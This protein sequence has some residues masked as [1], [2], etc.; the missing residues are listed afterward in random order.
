MRTALA[1]AALLTLTSPNA[2]RATTFFV[3]P[4]PGTPVQDAID[5]AGPGDTI[6]LQIGS[7]PERLHI[8]KAIKLRGVRSTSAQP[9]QTTV[10]GD[11]ACGV[12]PTIQIIANDV[13]LRGILVFGDQLG[14]V[15][16]QGNR[17]KL[18]DVFANPRCEVVSAPIFNVEAS[19]SVKLTKVW[20]AGVAT[21]TVPAGIRIA[22][23]VQNGRIR[24]SSSISGGNDVGILLENDATGSVR[25]S[26]SAVNY[27]LR[28]IV[29]QNTSG[30]IVDHNTLV[31]DTTAGIDLD[32][33]SSGNAIV[34]NSISGSAADV[35][36]AGSA[37]C[38]RN[39]TYSTGSV[40][41]CP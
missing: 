8:D 23:T 20:A 4:G 15:D 33:T 7:Y 36:D 40:P 19:T 38:W 6:R 27:N 2:G 13:Q 35:S 37:N 39:N 12:G 11:G 32:A 16:V 24:I 9:N 34:R 21:Q 3:P 17:I 14:G 25:V 26:R 41:A 1:L 28:G 22:N 30:A 29:L 31:N 18:T 5:A 10:V